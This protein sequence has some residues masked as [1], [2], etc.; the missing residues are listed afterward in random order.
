MAA[1]DMS[2]MLQGW[3]VDVP[4]PLYAYTCRQYMPSGDVCV[5][6]SKQLR[7]MCWPCCV[8]AVCGFAMLLFVL[9]LAHCVEAGADHLAVDY[10]MTSAE[11]SCC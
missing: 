10:N 6:V 9:Q 11:H 2:R 7:L 3:R 4:R 1:V 5:S 8:P